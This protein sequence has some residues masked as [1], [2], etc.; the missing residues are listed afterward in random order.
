MSNNAGKPKPAFFIAVLAVVAGLI[1]LSIYKCSGKSSKPAGQVAG[2]ID[3][4]IVAKKPAGPVESDDGAGVTTAKT[5][6]IVAADKL[7]P[8]VGTSDYKGIGPKRV[9]R[10]AINV[11]AGW[12]PIIAANGGKAAGKVWKAG[13]DKDGKP[14]ADFQVELVLI[15]DPKKMT[16]VFASGD[17]HVGWA[18]VDML[19]LM[20]S[21]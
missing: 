6:E 3:P 12:A 14:G 11:W 18:T 17:L 15:D 1:G 13:L 9:V 16:D 8:V 19:P 20:R 10:F 5:Y 4:S 7:Q 21:A 2:T